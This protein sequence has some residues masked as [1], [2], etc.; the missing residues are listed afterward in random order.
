MKVST[1]KIIISAAFLLL[2]GIVMYGVVTKL[3]DTK[4][5][6]LKA[7]LAIR[8]ETQLDT[9]VSIADATKQ[10]SANPAVAAVIQ[11]C[12]A[13]KRKQFDTLLDKLSTSI[14]PVELSQLDNLFFQC[15]NFYALQRS[16]MAS[17]LSREVEV[18]SDTVR[19]SQTL[20]ATSPA[21]ES[22]VKNWQDIAIAENKIASFFSQLVNL[23]GSIITALGAGKSADS[24]EVTATLSEV[25]KVRGQMVVL[26]KQVEDYR[27]TLLSI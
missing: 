4:I 21:P 17:I 1:S 15:G 5:T 10:N 27:T 11:D 20:H 3:V 14:S 22:V 8:T 6:T 26:S 23:Q 7:E 24:A 18:L 16:L 12:S 9:L 13:D 19:L 2:V 25:A